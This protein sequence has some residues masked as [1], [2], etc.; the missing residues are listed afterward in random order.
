M[1]AQLQPLSETW[2]TAH[3]SVL[4]QSGRKNM[5]WTLQFYFAFV[6]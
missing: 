1:I 6:H 5:G 2:P 4:L 3:N